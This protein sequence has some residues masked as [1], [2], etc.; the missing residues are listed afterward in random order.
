LTWLVQ[1]QKPQTI[2]Y[3]FALGNRRTNIVETYIKSKV[4]YSDRLKFKSISKGERENVNPKSLG[5]KIQPYFPTVNCSGFTEDK[6]YSKQAM[7]C[8]RTLISNIKAT[9]S[10]E[11]KKKEPTITNSDVL[12]KRTN[13]GEK[14]HRDYK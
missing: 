12:L 5:A 11:P 7:A 14:S 10:T 2:E 1:H 4:K 3:N 6:I 8:R 9:I 13:K